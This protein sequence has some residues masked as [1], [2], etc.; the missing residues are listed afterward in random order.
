MHST[1]SRK[2]FADWKTPS[3]VTL[4]DVFYETVKTGAKVLDFG[5]AW[6]RVP[7]ELQEKWYNVVWFDVNEDEIENAKKFKD[8]ANEKFDAQ[9]KFDV[10]NALELPYE[11]NA[12]DACLMQAFMVTLIDPTERKKVLD[13]AR[14]VLKKDGILYLG[15]FGQT[16]ENPKYSERYEAHYPKTQ[17]QWTFI[18]TEDGTPDTE[19][20]YR[21]HHYSEEELKNLLQDGFT[22][23][24]FK[25]VIFTS[26]HGNKANGFVVVARK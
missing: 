12:F 25:K 21:V 15:V 7:F 8:E 10:A 20:I 1:L 9:V 26:Y 2:Q 24:E 19:E 17:E 14:R 11:D 4:D 23:Q 3:S 6:G 16:W 18:V 22:I 13:E 5:C